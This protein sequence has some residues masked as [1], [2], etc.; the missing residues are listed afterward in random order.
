MSIELNKYKYIECIIIY[1]MMLTRKQKFSD[2]L[3]DCSS[4][5]LYTSEEISEMIALYTSPC[6]SV[7]GALRQRYYRVRKNYVV[8]HSNSTNILYK[9]TSPNLLKV[10][11]KNKLFNLFET[12]HSDDGKHL[13][14]DRLFTELK[15]QFAGFSRKI[16][17]KFVGMCPE[18]QLQ[19]S[20]K[21]LKSTVTKPIRSSDFASRGQVD[22]IDMQTSRAMNEP[23][24][25][26]LVYQDHLTKFIVLRLIKRKTAAEV[27]SILL[28]IFCL[29]GPPHILQSDNGKEFKNIDLAKMIRELWPG[30]KTVNGR[31]RH[32]KSQGSVERVITSSV[33]LN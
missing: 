30:C 28:D 19:K 33:N 18:C 9:A 16:V 10:V 26:L 22:L 2:F 20:K 14:R 15:K 5:S 8:K 29:I 31:P 23:Y 12:V 6:P 25:F 4:S 1:H 27:T 3:E 13:G 11:P 32:P 17:L 21:S 24:N 7:S